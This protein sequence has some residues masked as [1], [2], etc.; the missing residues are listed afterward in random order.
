METQPEFTWNW[1]VAGHQGLRQVNADAVASHTDPATGGLHVALADGIG[2]NQ[3]AVRAALVAAAAAVRTPA[4]AGGPEVALLAAQR[5]V[6]ADPDAADCV[7]VVAQPRVDGYELSWV[8]DVRAYAWDGQVLRQLT[9]DHTLAQF[10]RSRGEPFAPRME[11]VVT[12]SVRTARPTEFGRA[13][14][15]GP[16]RLLLT[17]DGVHKTLTAE[18]MAEL[19]RYADNP[20][21]ALVAAAHQAGSTDNTT[22]VTVDHASGPP[23]LPLP[24]QPL[25]TA[26]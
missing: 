20:A 2:D 10:F 8:G 18:A 6:Q 15:L 17:S 1:H 13:R 24:T 21:A 22:A 23:P 26:A 11:H 16:G 9:T 5:A 14:L 19:M 7:L 4:A 25:P 3:G 12:T